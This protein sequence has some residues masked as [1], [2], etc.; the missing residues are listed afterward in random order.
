MTAVSG[1]HPS[2]GVTTDPRDTAKETSV[3][4]AEM[5]WNGVPADPTQMPALRFFEIVC[6]ADHPHREDDD[7]A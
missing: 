2:R 7:G 1:V 3:F 5:P 6:R 4:F